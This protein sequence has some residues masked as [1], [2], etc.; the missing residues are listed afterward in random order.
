MSH[1]TRKGGSKHKKSKEGETRM[2]YTN[3]D[4]F[5][6]VK[7]KK[8]QNRKIDHVESNKSK[9]QTDRGDVLVYARESN[10]L[11]GGKISNEYCF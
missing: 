7:Q 5:L 11:Q 4:V 9:R 1:S 2:T 10:K 3:C 6:K 8:A